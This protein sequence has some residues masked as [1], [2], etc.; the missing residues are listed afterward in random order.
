MATSTTAAG[1]T[2]SALKT[3]SSAI[4][5]IKTP[6]A[7]Q[8]QQLGDISK[9]LS[10]ISQLLNRPTAAAD[11]KTPV[12]S[13]TA[14]PN[15]P[16]MTPESMQPQ[17]KVQLPQAP[18]FSQQ[19][20]AMAQAN[21]GVMTKI[22]Q[23]VGLNGLENT[24]LT[25]GDLAL[26]NAAKDL[27]DTQMDGANRL[28]DVYNNT[29]QQL[30]IDDNIKRIQE[31]NLQIGKI[32]EQ[33]QLGSVQIGDQTIATPIIGR[34]QRLLLEQ[35]AIKTGALAAEAQARQ[36]Y[37][38]LAR[39]TLSETIQLE[40]DVVNANVE[41]KKQM[42]GVVEKIGDRQQQ[43]QAAAE[44]R[45]FDI[46]KMDYNQLLNAKQTALKNATGKP[47]LI[48]AIMAADSMEQLGAIGGINLIDPMERAQ[49]ANIYNQMSNRDAETG[50]GGLNLTAKQ[51]S[52]VDSL[53]S[54]EA[55]FNNY[56]NLIN[57]TVGSSGVKLTGKEAAR[58]RTAKAAL[59]FAIAEAVGT[60]ALQA[61]DRDVVQDI[62]SDPTSIKRAG[63]NIMRGGKQGALSSLDEA[64]A[65]FNARRGSITGGVSVPINSTN[66]QTTSVTP[67]TIISSGGKQYRVAAD[68]DTLIPI[69]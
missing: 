10:G 7:T 38:E 24:D 56:R 35:T 26:I 34:Q 2:G 49:I 1:A 46:Y 41:Y 67:G 23:E 40:R 39:Q 29:R 4:S 14:Y 47:S 65:I 61:A 5:S 11:I 18:D 58:L 37:V 8:Q 51:K 28:R 20:K 48:Q 59:E 57:T 19:A 53:N 54:V 33:A 30:G 12:G 66:T 3:A 55:Q 60:G 16:V 31:L 50:S 13:G 22:A 64:K 52:Q 17:Q 15:F 43:K 68:G 27:G 44:A 69:N 45:A 6:T 25:G 36:G 42:L 21:S 9:T 63:G 62:I 32:N